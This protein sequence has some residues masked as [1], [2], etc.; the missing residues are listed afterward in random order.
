[1]MDQTTVANLTLY[2]TI[3][4]AVIGA[5]YTLWQIRAA[6]LVAVADLHRELTTGEV[7]DARHV[8]GSWLYSPPLKETIDDGSLIKSY[9]QLC[10]AVERVSNVLKA[11]TLLLVFPDGTSEGTKLGRLRSWLGG[12]AAQG[13]GWS[14]EEILRNIARLRHD[15]KSRLKIQD[16]DVQKWLR[17]KL[18]ASL[19]GKYTEIAE[20][21][22]PPAP[23]APTP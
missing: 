15:E 22:T 9:Y 3:V 14:I 12:D 13:L 18:I 2:A 23:T 19:S 7:A 8:I 5:F 21:L 10:W 16:D 6:N 11:R 20:R 17:E 1:M 4:I